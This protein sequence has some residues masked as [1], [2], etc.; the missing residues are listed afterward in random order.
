MIGPEYRECFSMALHSLAAHKLRSLLTMF[1]I[2]VGV[3][4]II[5]VMTTIRILQQNIEAELSQLG[6]STFR[7]QRWPALQVNTSRADRE[8][9]ARRK[10]LT[11]KMGLEL[12]AK[13]TLAQSVGFEESFTSKAAFSRHEKTNPNVSLI[14]VTPKTFAA[15]NWIVE[16]G[17]GFI[18]GDIDR[19]RRVCV[20]GNELAGKLFPRSNPVGDEIKFDGVSYAVVGVLESKGGSLGGNQG[21]FIAVPMTTGLQRYGTRRSISYLVQASSQATLDDTIDQVRAILRTLRKVEPNDADDFEVLS[22]DSLVTQFRSIT[23][24]VRLGAALVS[25]IALIVA[26]IGIMNIMLVSVTERTRE[27]GIR[28]AIGAKRKNILIQF[29]LEAVAV[30]QIGGMAG[31]LLGVLAG[32]YVALMLKLPPSIPLDWTLIGLGVCSLVGVIFGTYPAYKAA[33]LDPIAALRHG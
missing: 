17:R 21:N 11:Y 8:K 6:A 12:A 9:Y 27:I 3:F 24:A 15:K 23:M 26:G 7:V 32:N 5:V 25:S 16:Q 22:N 19:A 31:I 33:N 28:R 2:L 18:A 13:A 14:G 29:I 1:G 10:D 4:S 30:C 20:L